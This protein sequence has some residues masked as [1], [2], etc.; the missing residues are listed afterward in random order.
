MTRLNP[1]VCPSLCRSVYVSTLFV[2]N[3]LRAYLEDCYTQPSSAYQGVGKLPDS[4]LLPGM[5]TSVD[6][7]ALSKKV[8]PN[9]LSLSVVRRSMVNEGELTFLITASKVNLGSFYTGR[10]NSRFVLTEG[11]RRLKGTICIRAH[12]SED[13]NMQLEHHQEVEDT[14]AAVDADSVVAKIRALEDKVHQQLETIYREV[15]KTDLKELR[16]VLPVSKQKMDWTGNQA[17]LVNALH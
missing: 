3:A 12:Y 17:S 13:C 15:S 10:W 16:R 8:P 11:D 7:G 9:P 14:V 6:K 5:A 4:V 2:E 1:T